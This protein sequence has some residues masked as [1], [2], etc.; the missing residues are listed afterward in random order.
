M[1]LGTVNDK[2][3]QTWFMRALQPNLLKDAPAIWLYSWY[4]TS[5]QTK[6][7]L[8]FQFTTYDA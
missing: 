1:P 3:L 6:T 2:L 7:L 5:W 4:T 8:G